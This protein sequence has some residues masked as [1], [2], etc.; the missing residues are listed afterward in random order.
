V[1]LK[2]VPRVGRGLKALVLSPCLLC[3]LFDVSVAQDKPRLFSNV[4]R[5]L[6]ARDRTWKIERILTGQT[7][8]PLSESIK[9][10]DGRREAAIE[11]SIWR[12]LQDTREVFAG[13]VIAFDNVPGKRAVKRSLRDVG[14]ENYMWTNPRSNAWPTIYFRKGN[15]FVSVFAPSVPVATKFA[16][17]V[18]EQMKKG[19]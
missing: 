1:S 16:E 19:E 2:F 9:L 13:Q 11:I 6:Q 12:R 15:V 4:E 18:L 10:R 5:I 3:F 14:D 8:D 7:T 17:Q